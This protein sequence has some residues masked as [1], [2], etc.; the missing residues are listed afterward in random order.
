MSRPAQANPSKPVVSQ[1]VAAQQAATLID[2][3]PW[4]QR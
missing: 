4:L 1:E 3:L 2:A